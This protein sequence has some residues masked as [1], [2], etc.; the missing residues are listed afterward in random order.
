[1]PQIGKQLILDEGN[2]ILQVKFSLLQPLDLQHVR[3]WRVLKRF[4]GSVKVAVLLHQARQIGAELAFLLF[5]HCRRCIE[6]P[7]GAPRRTA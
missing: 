5:C 7:T 2:P 1:M 4:D 6:M 3:A